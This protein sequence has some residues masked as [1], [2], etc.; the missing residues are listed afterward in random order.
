MQE[1]SLVI[2]KFF[3][4]FY[5]Y[6]SLSS[7]TPMSI[8]FVVW[9]KTCLT[10]TRNR[11]SFP[12]AKILC[13]IMSCGSASGYSAWQPRLEMSSSSS[14]GRKIKE[15]ERWELFHSNISVWRIVSLLTCTHLH[16][17]HFQLILSPIRSRS[18]EQ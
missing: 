11:M 15:V 3:L 9:Q 1:L 13:P 4:L 8:A 12:H 10:V 17:M 14:G 16:N 18:Y 2:L 7:A 5:L 6:F